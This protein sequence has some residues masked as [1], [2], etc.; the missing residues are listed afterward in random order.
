MSVSKN[1]IKIKIKIKIAR[2]ISS[3][4]FSVLGWAQ[5]CQTFLSLYPTP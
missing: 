3:L 4:L 2:L 5:V 1:K